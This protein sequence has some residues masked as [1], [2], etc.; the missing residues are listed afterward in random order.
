[1]SAVSGRKIDIHILYILVIKRPAISQASTS[2]IMHFLL[3]MFW[4]GFRWCHNNIFVILLRS[5]ARPKPSPGHDI[6]LGLAWP[7]WLG[8][9][10]LL[11]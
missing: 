5:G 7:V 1:M 9:A 4:L 8:L 10:W 6:W 3:V 11:A 2:S